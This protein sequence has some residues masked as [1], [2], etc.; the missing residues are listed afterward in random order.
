MAHAGEMVPA[1]GLV[2]CDKA[3]PPGNGRALR[4]LAVPA[5]AASG[6]ESCASRAAFAHD[7]GRTET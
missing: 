6:T 3:S 7:N 4:G 1:R 5:Y 2:E